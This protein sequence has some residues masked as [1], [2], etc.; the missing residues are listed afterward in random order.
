VADSSDR[1]GVPLAVPQ[2]VETVRPLLR[3]DVPLAA[4]PVGDAAVLDAALNLLIFIPFA[5]LAGFALEARGW[6]PSSALGVAFVATAVFSLA[7]ESAQYFTVSRSSEIQ[8]VVLN[9]VSGGPGGVLYL[10]SRGRA[11]TGASP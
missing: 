1:A 8:D 4:R 11:S 2:V 6:Q 7:V 9:V 5:L 3:Q 10:L